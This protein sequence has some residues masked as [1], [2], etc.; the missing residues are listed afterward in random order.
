MSALLT[1]LHPPIPNEKTP[2]WNHQR[3]AFWFVWNLWMAGFK[4]AMLAMDMGT[5]K[6]KV[7]IDLAGMLKPQTLLILAPLRVVDVW[8]AQLEQHASFPYVFCGLDDRVR[9]TEKKAVLAR[10]AMETAR[11]LHRAAVIAIN[12]ESMWLEPF[13]SLALHTPWGLVIADEI[14]RCK[15]PMGKQSRFLKQLGFRTRRK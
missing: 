14:H 4:G 8:R 1:E 3:A 10:E 5:G 12:Y 2:A 13:R 7:A 11:R 6:T 9:G 15:A